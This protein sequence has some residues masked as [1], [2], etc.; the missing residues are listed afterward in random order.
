MANIL[1]HQTAIGA[2]DNE[3][4]ALQQV[5]A[6][7]QA[8]QQIALL[9]PDGIPMPLPPSVLQVLQQTVAHLAH[10][11][12][13]QVATIPDKLSPQQAADIL[14]IPRSYLLKLLEQGEIPFRQS[15][16]RRQIL[17]EDLLRYKQA[18]D[19]RERQGL[20]ELTRLSQEMGRYAD[21]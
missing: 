13:V 1:D 16:A 18:R 14:N 11:E 2:Q 7:L 17:L 4:S 3:H 21:I 9:G 20:A 19:E 8:G 12:H 5:Q 6:A 15:G 10:G